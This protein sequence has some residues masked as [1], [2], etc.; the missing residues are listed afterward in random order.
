[1]TS[2]MYP[3]WLE[4][5]Q[6]DVISEGH[7][8]QFRL[9]VYPRAY[10]YGTGG[11]RLTLTTDEASEIVQAFRRR[12]SDDGGPLVTDEQADKGRRYLARYADRL[13]L[14]LDVSYRNI[15]RF[16]FE[17]VHHDRE[18]DD[19]WRMSTAPIYRAFWDDGTQL[20][21]WCT[22]WTARAYGNNPDVIQF[23]IIRK[24]VA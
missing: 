4:R 9:A 22:P 13:G 1:M 2:R 20:V 5:V 18:G 3:V 16:R 7:I 21:Y 14:P 12:V 8:R 15:D 23:S 17:A 10:G 6:A 11:H 19:R 24:E